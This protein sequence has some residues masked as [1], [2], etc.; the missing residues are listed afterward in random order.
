MWRAGAGVALLLAAGAALGQQPEPAPPIAVPRTSSPITIDGSLSDPAWKEAAVVDAFWE[1]TPGDNVPPKVRTVAYLAYDDRFFYI[2]VRCEDPEAAR[3]RAPY[4]ERD[5]VIG[6]DDNVAIFLDTRNDRRS[7]M[8]FRVNPR[9]IQADAMWNDANFDEDFSP[10]FFYDTAAQVLPEGWTAEVRIPFS[11]LRY[12]KGDPQTWGILIWRNYPRDFRYAIY[13]SRLPRGSN[14]LICH[15]RELT[16]LEGLPSGAHYVIAP[17][18]SGKQEGVPRDPADPDSSFFNMPV[19]PDGGGDVKWIPN[20]DT[21]VDATINPDFSQVES[22]VAQIAVNTRFAL[23]FPEKRPFFLEGVDLLDTPIPAVHTRTITSPL[24][25]ARGT[26]Q[27]GASTYTLLVTQDRGG[28]S[29]ILPGPQFS[30]F[31]PQD[32]ESYAAIGRLRRDFG[33]SF[34][35]LL[36][37]D[38]DIVGGGHNIVFGPDFQWALGADDRIT[39]QFLYSESREPDRPDLTPEWDGERLSGHG[40]DLAWSHSTRKLFSNLRYRD[41][42]DEFRADDGFVPQ[43]GYREGIAEA[44]L[45]FYPE[46]GLFNFLQPRAGLDYTEDREGRLL[47]R[48]IFPGVDFQGRRNLGGFVGANLDTVRVG[49][50]LLD[51]AYAAFNIQVDPSRRIT[52]IGVTGSIGRQIDFE[53]AREGTGGEI[54]LQVM[55]RPTDHLELSMLGQCRW[56]DVRAESGSEGRLFTATVAR[57]KATYVFNAR[58]FLRAIG[59]WVETRRDPA[60]YTFPVAPREG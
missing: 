24:W 19:E 52:R 21:A 50:S 12:P 29:V 7:A 48:R 10:D 40:L 39:G 17:Y 26:G 28:G 57:F 60:L 33:R 45:R 5:Q 58:L 36:V 32:F 22:D 41:F 20:P 4:V 56:L 59:Q 23:F 46:T 15:M 44:G 3:V 16:G 8:E 43:V 27:I 37:T 54:A 51:A 49:E 55:A 34:G 31:A 42:S 35:G 38:R 2:G 30:I 53:N 13:S 6:T 18:V 47:F 25:G 9:G 14:C 1:T 11:T